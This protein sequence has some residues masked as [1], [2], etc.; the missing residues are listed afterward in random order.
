MNKTNIDLYLENLV[1]AEKH[2]DDF[3][4]PIFIEAEN[5]LSELE[6]ANLYFGDPVIGKQ[7]YV[8]FFETNRDKI[9]ILIKSKNSYAINALGYYYYCLGCNY[10]A[11]VVL[12]D[13]GD[14][15][16]SAA[17][18]LAII[19]YIQDDKIFDRDKYIKYLMLLLK[20]IDKNHPLGL[21]LFGNEYMDFTDKSKN[22]AETV[23]RFTDAILDKYLTAHRR[24]NTLAPKY[25]ADFYRKIIKCNEDA[26]KWYKIAIKNNKN[27]SAYLVEIYKELGETYKE[28]KKYNLSTK[29]LKL[30]LK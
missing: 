23:K 6:F 19:L 4:N 7:E 14:I 20:T 5:Y 15:N 24:G 10:K 9:D 28:M 8:S 22:D 11:V 30:S 2:K 1:I 16:S 25:I 13:V 3:N 27:K 21:L 29:Y 26:C 18:L 12:R 17:Y